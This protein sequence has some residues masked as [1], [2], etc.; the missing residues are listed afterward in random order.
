MG[1]I[2]QISRDIARGVD[3]PDLGHYGVVDDFIAVVD[4]RKNLQEAFALKRALIQR[5]EYQ[6]VTILRERSEKQ[7]N[8]SL[9]RIGAQF[10]NKKFGLQASMP[11]QSNDEK[12]LKAERRRILRDKGATGLLGSGPAKKATIIPCPQKHKFFYGVGNNEFSSM[13]NILGSRFLGQ[14]FSEILKA[15][16][17]NLPEFLSWNILH[18]EITSTPGWIHCDQEAADA[19]SRDLDELPAAVLEGLANFQCLPGSVSVVS[20]LNS[21]GSF[22]FKDRDIG[23]KEFFDDDS[24]RCAYQVQN[25]DVSGVRGEG[26]PDDPVTGEPRDA[27]YHCSP[28][29]NKFGHVGDHRG[30]VVIAAHNRVCYT[31]P[32]WANENDTLA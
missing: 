27:L 23:E 5:A 28:L 1:R 25:G 29:K 6:G 3:D 13:F 10:Y 31:L 7:L 18:G 24:D 30:R 4:G 14:D 11:R 12:W 22:L 9:E 17:N 21:G 20:A 8:Q 2:I 19:V 26:W 15:G 16:R 32:Q